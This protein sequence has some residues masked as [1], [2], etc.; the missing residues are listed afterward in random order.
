MNIPSLPNNLA[1]Q[2]LDQGFPGPNVQVNTNLPAPTS[3]STFA[4]VSTLN[5]DAQEESAKPNTILTEN[6][7][8]NVHHINEFVQSLDRNLK[9]E[10]S[11]DG[12]SVIITVINAQ[13]EEVIRQIPPEEIQLISR[14]LAQFQTEGLIFDRKV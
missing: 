10:I 6:L 9:F 13:T 8:E 3:Q 2:N 14:N 4:Q 1:T 11:E 7:S 12:S 5:A